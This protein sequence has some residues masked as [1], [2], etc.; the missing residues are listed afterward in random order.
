MRGKLGSLHT[1]RLQIGGILDW[2]LDLNLID[3]N[4]DATTV[5]KLAKWKVV[6]QSYWLFDIPDKVVV[7]LYPNNGKGCWEGKGIITFS[8]K[9]F[10]TLI[11]KP[12]EIIG[13]GVLEGKDDVKP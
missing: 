1:G 10:N 9:L 5:Y 8:Q 12:L 2:E 6:A 7:R 4:E 3:Y 11:H 13:E